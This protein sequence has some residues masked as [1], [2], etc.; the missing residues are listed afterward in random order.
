MLGLREI[1][2]NC[3]TAAHYL[4]LKEGGGNV[5]FQVNRH[6]SRHQELADE[7]VSNACGNGPVVCRLS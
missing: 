6:F 5:S 3:G 4:G 2:G 7:E 1:A